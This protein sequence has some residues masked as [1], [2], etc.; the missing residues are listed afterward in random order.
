MQS[1]PIGHIRVLSG[2]ANTLINAPIINKFLSNCI[3]YIM[4]QRPNLFAKHAIGSYVYWVY[5]AKCSIHKNCSI[6]SILSE[7]LPAMH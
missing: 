1:N 4:S 5:C 7:E 2:I 3:F 6:E